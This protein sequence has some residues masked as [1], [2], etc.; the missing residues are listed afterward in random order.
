M[1]AA[2]VA[3]LRATRET[4]AALA[5]RAAR[6]TYDEQAASG[7]AET[8][9]ALWARERRLVNAIGRRYGPADL[10]GVGN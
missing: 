1:R 5:E 9:E 7:L 4:L 6:E 3:D 8:R 2:L 10:T